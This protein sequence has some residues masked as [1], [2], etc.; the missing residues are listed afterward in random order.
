MA[1]KSTTAAITTH[2]KTWWVNSTLSGVYT[3]ML[4]RM[5][6]QLEAMLSHHSRVI[7]I[8]FDLRQPVYTADNKRM[9][10]FNRRLFKWLK[11]KYKV[12]RIGYAWAREQ[13]KSKQQHYH[14]ALF[15]DGHKIKQPSA[16][17][18]KVQDIWA[19]MG[20][21]YW[22]PKNCYYNLS[23]NVRHNTQAAIWRI[24]YLAKCRGKGYK[25]H[26]TKNYSTSRLKLKVPP[27]LKIP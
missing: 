2:G 21:S 10:I 20:G 1:Y 11:A 8:R 25:P 23:R 4:K 7:V 14:Y 15:I 26:Q 12:T 17:L 9:T 5:I 13:E 24:S 18:K 19:E 16:V 6:G 3:P 27:K 22:V